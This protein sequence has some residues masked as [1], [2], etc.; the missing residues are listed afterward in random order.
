MGH[1]GL[2]LEHV[3]MVLVQDLMM[4]SQC[5]C[6]PGSLRSAPLEAL[7]HCPLKLWQQAAFFRG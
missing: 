1:E 3:L 6:V 4:P 5:W 7:E 2:L